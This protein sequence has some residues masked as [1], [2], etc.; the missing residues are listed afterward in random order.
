M[1]VES[2]PLRILYSFPHQ[3][4]GSG[5]GTTAL[6]QVGSLARQGADVTLIC[7]SLK[8]AIQEGVRVLETL[9]YHGRRIP[10]RAFGSPDLALLYHDHRVA[11]YLRKNQGQFDVVHVWPQSAI[12]TIRAARSVGCLSSREVPNTHTANAYEQAALESTVTG[13][14]LARGHSHRR[15]RR[16]MRLEDLEYSNV[17]ILMVPSDNVARTFLERGFSEARIRRHR[18]GFDNSRFSAEGRTEWPSRPF[19][20]L[21]VGSGQP[22]KGLH[23]ALAAWQRATVPEGA[24][25]L[26]AGEFVP[27]YREHLSPWLAMESVHEVGFVTDVPAL[28]RTCDV[29]LLPSVEEGS[30]LVTYEGQGSGC[31]P[32]VSSAT[33]A[34]LP[35]SV[36]TFTEHSPRDVDALAEQLSAVAMDPSLR[37]HLRQDVVQWA[38]RLTWDA[39][40]RQMIEIYRQALSEWS[41]ASHV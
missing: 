26:I 16:R 30:A 2:K 29:L 35:P 25:L 10:H 27:G 22:R 38:Q 9:R 21:F 13:V 18:Y 33:G 36:R 23:Y 20:A 3:V 28:M 11:S 8:I 40:A 24:R 17:D 7:T 12:A 19:T 41:T 32:L 4:G 34:N 37:S 1:S 6:N 39:A 5:I 31:I 14:G 15:N